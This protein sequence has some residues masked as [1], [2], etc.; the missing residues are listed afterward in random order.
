MFLNPVSTLFIS[1]P[2]FCA[3]A[4]PISPVTIDFTIAGFLGILFLSFRAL[5][6]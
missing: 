6:M 5:M 4:V 2:N 1:T 3:M